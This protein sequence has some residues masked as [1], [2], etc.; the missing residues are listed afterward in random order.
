MVTPRSTARSCRRTHHHKS[1]WARILLCWVLADS[2]R[3]KGARPNYHG[4]KRFELIYLVRLVSWNQYTNELNS[5]RISE[6][7]FKKLALMCLSAMLTSTLS[8]RPCIPCVT[9][10]I[11]WSVCIC[12]CGVVMA[13]V[14]ATWQAFI[15][16][17]KAMAKKRKKKNDFLS[18][19]VSQLFLLM[20]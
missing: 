20:G 11:E 4:S 1:L 9:C 17:W 19:S 5:T 3:C 8:S 15:N 12:T 7:I 16:V 10:T 6:N 2:C 13:V 18:N 14:T